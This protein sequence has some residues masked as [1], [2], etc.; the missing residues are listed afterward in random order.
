MVHKPSEIRSVILAEHAVL[1]SRLD[2]IEAALERSAADGTSRR[3]LPGQLTRFCEEFLRHI[4][5]EETILMPVLADIDNWGPIRIEQMDAEH[6]EQRRTMDE[7]SRRSPDPDFAGYAA[8]V[9]AFVREIRADME[10]EE[11]ECL[12]RDVLRDDTTNIDAF[13]G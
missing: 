3:S 11:R 12:S 13:G 10:S 2:E 7:L 9:R 6:A 1:R 5:H 8:T 4:E